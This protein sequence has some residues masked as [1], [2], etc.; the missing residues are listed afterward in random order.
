MTDMADVIPLTKKNVELN[1]QLQSDDTEVF[2]LL[3]ENRVEAMEYVWGTALLQAS[4]VEHESETINSNSQNNN[5]QIFLSWCEESDIIVASDVVYYPEAY[6]PLVTTIHDLLHCSRT[7]EGSDSLRTNQKR[8]MILAHRHRHPE[9][10][11]FFE[12]LYNVADLQ[13]EEIRWKEEMHQQQA[14]FQDIRLFHILPLI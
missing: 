11:K 1:K 4:A 12:L 9:D 5:Q 14:S 6:Q 7:N 10:H 2:R 3:Q 8:H 13:I